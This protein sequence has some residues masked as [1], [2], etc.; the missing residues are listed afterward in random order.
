MPLADRHSVAIREMERLGFS[1]YEARTYV[2]LLEAQPANGYDLAKL[3]GVPT[4]KIYETL[5]RLVVKGAALASATEPVVYRATNPEELIA[6]FQRESDRTL[7]VLSESLMDFEIAPVGGVVWRL[8]GERIIRR[9][10]LDLAGRATRDLHLSLWPTEADYIADPVARA[11]ERGVAIWAASFGPSRLAGDGVYYMQTCGE[12]SS[13]RLGRRL[14]VAVADEREALVAEFSD[15][16]EPYGALTDD[17]SLAL[18]AR[19][20]IEHDILCTVLIEAL[21]PERVAALRRGYPRLAD[22]LGPAHTLALPARA[23]LR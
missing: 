14:T 20:F 4:S 17:A 5:K 11:R 3:S 6:H 23:E 10:L 22:L 12:T 9:H 16:A 19:E 21:G 15:G 1:S 18:I 13:V 7:R 2:A 8:Q